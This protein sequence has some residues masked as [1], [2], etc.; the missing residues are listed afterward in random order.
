[1]MYV[2]FMDM[3]NEKGLPPK[4]DNLPFGKQPLFAMIG[5]PVC[6]ISVIFHL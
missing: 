6:K 1:M 4:E 3:P 2:F 5:K